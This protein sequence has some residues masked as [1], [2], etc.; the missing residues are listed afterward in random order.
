MPNLAFQ[1]FSSKPENR[2]AIIF[3]HGFN[4]DLRNS[5]RNIPTI[6]HPD[7][8]TKPRYLDDWDLAG[9]GYSS[10]KWFDLAGL[11]SADATLTEVATMLYTQTVTSAKKYD[12]IAFIAHSMGGIVVQQAIV[13]HD[14]LRKRVSR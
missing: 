14:D 5:W 2:A 12:R 13:T 8:P 11:R 4:G 1:L 10:S 6:L 9:F 7:D 3:V